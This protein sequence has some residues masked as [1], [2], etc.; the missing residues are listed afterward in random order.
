MTNDSTAAAEG[1]WIDEVRLVPAADPGAA[2]T[3]LGSLP[4]GGNS[5]LAGGDSYVR[6]G[7]VPTA[8]EP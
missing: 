1:S 7:P 4:S 3:L 2:G 5:P 6:I 8:A